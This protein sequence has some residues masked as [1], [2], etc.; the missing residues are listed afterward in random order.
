MAFSSIL[1][2]VRVTPFPMP[3]AFFRTGVT[4]R[5]A[6][7][8]LPPAPPALTTAAA[9]MVGP[10]G[11]MV[12]DG[13]PGNSSSLW[14]GG[15][16]P[17]PQQ[18]HH[19]ISDEFASPPSSAPGVTAGDEASG[20]G[21]G[22]L[23]VGEKRQRRDGG[24][25][26]KYYGPSCSLGTVVAEAERSRRPHLPLMSAPANPNA[27]A[28]LTVTSAKSRKKS[29]AGGAPTRDPSSPSF[30]ASEAWWAQTARDE[31]MFAVPGGLGGAG[32]GNGGWRPH[33]LAQM[34]SPGAWLLQGTVCR[35]RGAG[36][37]LPGVSKVS[38]YLLVVGWGG[39]EG[40]GD[41][42][43]VGVGER[44]GPTRALQHLGRR[45]LLTNLPAGKGLGERGRVQYWQLAH[46]TQGL[47]VRKK[48][49]K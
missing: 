1:E 2:S 41:H 14:S 34:G 13:S 17:S 33:A 42:A 26:A 18:R 20:G 44:G 27:N 46:E 9:A 29:R 48:N 5:V 3:R 23:T 47:R 43:W 32:G 31:I 10:D 15:H 36:G 45:D 40:G 12:V 37:A 30:S 22:G 38:L 25:G 28:T 35:G 7:S 16:L 4:P 39:R 21:G 8:V 24:V 6:L 49:K 19:Q 11:V